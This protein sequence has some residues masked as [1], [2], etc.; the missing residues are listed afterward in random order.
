MMSTTII[1][2]IVSLVGLLFQQSGVE[3]APEKIQ[4]TIEVVM[5]FVGLIVVYYGRYKQGD[6]K[7]SGMKK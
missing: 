1:G 2:V 5:Q 7:W 6:I 4:T 3:V